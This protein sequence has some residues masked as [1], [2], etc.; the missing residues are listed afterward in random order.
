MSAPSPCRHCCYPAGGSFYFAAQR[1][2]GGAQC[3]RM[4][5]GGSAGCNRAN[6]GLDNKYRPGANGVGA[7]SAS[8]RRAKNRLAT[9][10][11]SE[12]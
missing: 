9:V 10:C 6:L 4:G 2:M 11:S 12:T 8:V 7:L 1:R 5:A 3:T